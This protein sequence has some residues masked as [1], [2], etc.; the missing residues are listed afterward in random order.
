MVQHRSGTPVRNHWH[1]STG[2]AD[3]IN[4]SSR[5]INIYGL[6]V[7]NNST[8]VVAYVKLYD[9]STGISSVTSTGGTV[10]DA[11]YL[12]PAA[13][14]PSTQAVGAGFVKSYP[15]GLNFLKGLSYSIVTGTA[16]NSTV[17]VTA[18]TI[19][20]NIQHDTQ[21]ILAAT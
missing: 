2:N 10:P 7:W 13:V 9:I 1:L 21:Y 3:Y 4:V 12:I 20:L 5:P 19:G 6:D 14:G 8:G 15:G 11:V 17:G 16:D 18:G